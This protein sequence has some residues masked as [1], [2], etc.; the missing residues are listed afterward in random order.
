[1]SLLQFDATAFDM[2]VLKVIE[3]AMQ[4]HAYEVVCEPSP[5]P[6]SMSRT[7]LLTGLMAQVDMLEYAG[8]WLM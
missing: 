5:H 4:K 1:M 8:T 3:L 2:M 7:I 6:D